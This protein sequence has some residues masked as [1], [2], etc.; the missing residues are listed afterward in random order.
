M[1]WKMATS[2]SCPVRNAVSEPPIVQSPWPNM[3]AN[4]AC[5]SGT[6]RVAA[7]RR[8]TTPAGARRSR[9]G[10]QE[11]PVD[12]EGDREP[13]SEPH[14][15]RPK[16]SLMMSVMMNTTG[17][18]MTPAVKTA[19]PLCAEEAPVERRHAER[20][21][22][23]ED[24]HADELGDQ[25]IRDEQSRER[26]EKTRRA[27]GDDGRSRICRNAVHAP[28]PAV[29]PSSQQSLKFPPGRDYT[30]RRKRGRYNPRLAQRRKSW[31]SPCSGGSSLRPRNWRA[32]GCS[33]ASASSRRGRIR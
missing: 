14:A 30:R 16:C 10:E 19:I 24:L 27:G 3:A 7:D 31:T 12:D 28:V 32:K 23:R 1:R 29:C 13:R 2:I 9:V 11:R 33:S 18:S 22:E 26:D 15:A 25:G 20:V 4:A 5:M 6:P 8:P 21:L 17:Q